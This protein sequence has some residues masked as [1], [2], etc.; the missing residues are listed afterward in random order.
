MGYDLRERSAGGDQE[1]RGRGHGEGMLILAHLDHTAAA[2]RVGLTLRPTEVLVFGNPPASTP[3]MQASQ[4]MGID[5]PGSAL[6]WQD[7]A[8][9]T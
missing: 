5:L 6:V 8:G 9:M 1:A 3:I 7:E 2:E 4:T